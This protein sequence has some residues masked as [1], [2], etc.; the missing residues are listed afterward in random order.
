MS[1]TDGQTADQGYGETHFCT[2]DQL[3]KG[4]TECEMIICLEHVYIPWPTNFRCICICIAY[5]L[6][7]G[8]TM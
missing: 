3:I 5:Q 1:R 7:K 6:I 8:K 2:A 4:K